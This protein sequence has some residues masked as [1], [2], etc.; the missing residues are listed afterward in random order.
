MATTQLQKARLF[1]ALHERAGAF[2]IPNP[3]D[4]GTAKILAALGFEALA[5]TS[6]GLANSLGRPDG[7]GL[8]DGDRGRHRL[9]MPQ[10][11]ARR[12]EP[13]LRR[14][15]R[16]AARPLSEGRRR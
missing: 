9:V 10:E 3:W 8:V 4:A 15:G 7:A 5:T 13:F 11:G 6:L 2:I 12:H 1:R 16:V 14:G